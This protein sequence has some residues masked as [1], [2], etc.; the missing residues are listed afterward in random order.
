MIVALF[1]LSDAS[2]LKEFGV[3]DF[4]IAE[5]GRRYFSNDALLSALRE[6][7]APA[8]RLSLGKVPSAEIYM[9]D[10]TTAALLNNR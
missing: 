3:G 1:P 6:S 7:S 9:L 10:E 8:F 4:V 5:R 2:A